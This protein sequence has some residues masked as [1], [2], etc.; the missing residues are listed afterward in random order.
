MIGLMNISEGLKLKYTPLLV[1]NG[2]QA[3]ITI[4][5]THKDNDKA[6]CPRV[7]NLRIHECSPQREMISEYVKSTHSMADLTCLKFC[8]QI[9]SQ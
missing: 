8:F 4:S 5:R 9:L 7:Q 6:K 3:A 1:Y 2:N